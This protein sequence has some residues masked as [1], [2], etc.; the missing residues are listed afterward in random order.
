LLREVQFLV[1]PAWARSNGQSLCVRL[2]AP[3]AAER[4]LSRL[5]AAGVAARP[6][7]TNAHEEPEQRDG[8]RAPLPR[9]EAARRACVL[10]PLPSRMRDDELERVVAAVNA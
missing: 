4:L 9:S 1:E 3:D 10:L 2:P 5:A 6:G 8:M 7:L